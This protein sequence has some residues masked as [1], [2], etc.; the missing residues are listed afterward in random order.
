MDPA[1]ALN[2][3]EV[4]LMNGDRHEARTKSEI[5]KTPRSR[6]VYEEIKD[7]RSLIVCFIVYWEPTC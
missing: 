3:E 7:S 6:I 4:P 5:Q 2:E 1:T